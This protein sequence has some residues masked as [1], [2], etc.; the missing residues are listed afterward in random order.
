MEAAGLGD[1]T[2]GDGGRGAAEVIGSGRTPAGALRE[3]QFC[4]LTLQAQHASSVALAK[5]KRKLAPPALMKSI[6]A[7]DGAKALFTDHLTRGATDFGSRY[8]ATGNLPLAY[9]VEGLVRARL[10]DGRDEPGFVYDLVDEVAG[11]LGM[12]GWY[13]W[14]G[15]EE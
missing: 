11:V 6:D 1:H 7:L 14:T 4:G 13:E 10:G 15:E 8:R 2:A 3:A 9:K 12:T 5:D